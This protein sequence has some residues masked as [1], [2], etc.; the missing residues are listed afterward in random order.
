MTRN[1]VAA[2]ATHYSPSPMDPHRLALRAPSVVALLA[3][4]LE[5]AVA[6]AVLLAACALAGTPIGLPELTLALIV[7][8]LAWSGR[9]RWR[10]PPRRAALGILG[11]WSVVLAVVG[12]FGWATGA[13]SFFDPLALAL[14]GGATP[15]AQWAAAQAGRR[16]RGAVLRWRGPR[17]VVIAGG[18]E[19]GMRVWRVLRRRGDEPVELLGVFDDRT[20]DRVATPLRPHLLGRLRELP[21]WLQRHGAD[22][23]YVTLP[24]NAERAGELLERLH[25]AGVRVLVVPDEATLGLL[26]GRRFDVGGLVVMELRSRRPARAGG[27]TT[28]GAPSTIEPHDPG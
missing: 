20:D 11:R 23:V 10:E 18:G 8:A 16:L 9:D 13:L 3:A 19:A 26:R 17:R 25:A 1:V 28:I 15:L 6:V 21:G 4:A 27:S 24:S 7:A 22:D 14:W 5:P 2:Q 12:L